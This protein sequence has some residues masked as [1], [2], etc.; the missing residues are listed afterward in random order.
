MK[1]ARGKKF[2]QAKRSRSGNALL[3]Q[4][5]MRAVNHFFGQKS[6]KIFQECLCSNDT[7]GYGYLTTGHCLTDTKSSRRLEAKSLLDRS[8]SM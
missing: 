8:Y 7:T 1:D 4:N 2:L 6:L 5:L 3:L